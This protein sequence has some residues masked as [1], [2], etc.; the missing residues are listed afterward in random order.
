MVKISHSVGLVPGPAVAP[1]GVKAMGSAFL[2]SRG[3]A[4][5]GA[6]SA[7]GRWCRARA[8]QVGY[9]SAGAFGERG[10]W[11]SEVVAP[12]EAG[13]GVHPGV[14]LPDPRQEFVQA[15][16]QGD[17]VVR[18]GVV[19]ALIVE[20]DQGDALLG[21]VPAGPAEHGRGVVWARG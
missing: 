18:L 9:R 13:V 2:I 16:H 11:S 20:G 19:F 6:L 8:G 21:V 3:G 15:R 7:P 1:G 10:E 14:P 4:G 12:V 17:E 5:S